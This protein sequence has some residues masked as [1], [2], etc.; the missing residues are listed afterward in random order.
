MRAACLHS[1]LKTAGITNFACWF[2]GFSSLRLVLGFE[3]L[4]G[5]EDVT[6]PFASYGEL[7][8]VSATSFDNSKIKKYASV[9]YGCSRLM[10]G[11]DGFVPMPGSGASVLKL[12]AGG[13]LT[14][15]EYDIRT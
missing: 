10:G 13:V 11:V 15:P 2:N 14:D 7:H 6:Q 1:S 3:N 9:L 5:T 8:T 4:S 12:G